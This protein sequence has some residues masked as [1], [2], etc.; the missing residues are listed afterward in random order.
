MSLEG[1][2]A[3]MQRKN[4][5]TVGAEFDE[6]HLKAVIKQAFFGLIVFINAALLSMHDVYYTG[7]SF[8]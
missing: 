1:Y 7:N 3:H 2:T 6:R 5:D 8:V 4:S